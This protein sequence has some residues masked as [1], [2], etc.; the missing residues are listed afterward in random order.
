M[1]HHPLEMLK[2]LHN[3]PTTPEAIAVP[4]IV[5]ITTPDFVQLVELATREV[6]R[7]D[8]AYPA[9]LVRMLNRQY[10]RKVFRRY[11]SQRSTVKA[12]TAAQ[13]SRVDGKTVVEGWG[14]F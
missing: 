7:G 10:D 6:L 11:M 13:I 14:A 1:T 8:R 9:H 4:N 5:S 3:A 2:A 12:T